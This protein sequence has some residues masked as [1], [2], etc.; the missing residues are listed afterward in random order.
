M[1]NQLLLNGIIAGSIYALIALGFT[2]IY[3][4]VRFF[5]FAHG[6]VYTAGAYFAYSL[7]IQLGI[8]PI[9]SFFLPRSFQPSSV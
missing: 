6:V 1:F 3:K 7:S 2:V 8:N 4:T 9:L 5:H